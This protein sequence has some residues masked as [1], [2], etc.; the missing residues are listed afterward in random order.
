MDRLTPLIYS[1]MVAIG[2]V[3]KSVLMPDTA[4][5]ISGK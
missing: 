2:T 5:V 1:M 3:E 4:P